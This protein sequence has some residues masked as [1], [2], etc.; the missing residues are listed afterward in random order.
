[1]SAV[2]FRNTKT[3]DCYKDAFFKQH[4]LNLSWPSELLT[5]KKHISL[6]HLVVTAERENVQNQVQLSY[7]N[8]L[9]A[10][11]I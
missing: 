8:S 11:S 6:Q 9:K 1:M 3:T 7:F 10:H 4:I 5:K 2:L